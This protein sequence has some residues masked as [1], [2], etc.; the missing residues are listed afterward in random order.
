MLSANIQEAFSRAKFVTLLL[1]T[2]VPGFRSQTATYLFLG[3][4]TLRTEMAHPG[5][6]PETTVNKGRVMDISA[7]E[8]GITAE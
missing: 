7:L 3:L 5:S 1:S 8:N 6:H 2:H 4:G